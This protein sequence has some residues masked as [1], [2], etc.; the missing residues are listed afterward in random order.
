MS[1][2]ISLFC[3]S[4]ALRRDNNRIETLYIGI[5]KGNPQNE[6]VSYR[7]TVSVGE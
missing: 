6:R 7:M 2:S 1:Q 4:M 3:N 5:L